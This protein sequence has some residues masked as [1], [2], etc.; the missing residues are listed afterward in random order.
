MKNF[1]WEMVR[2]IYE[3]KCASK[4]IPFIAIGKYNLKYLIYPN[5]A[6]DI[7]ICKNGI[8]GDFL[9]NCLNQF[10]DKDGVV[11]DI[12]ANVGL[13][14]LPFS[15]IHVPFGKVISF[16]PDEENFIQLKTNIN[17]NKIE[18]VIALP[19]ALQGDQAVGKINFNIRRAVDGDG[20]VNRGLSSLVDIDLH[21]VE[22]KEVVASTIDKEIL[23]LKLERLDFIKIDV[24]GMECDVLKGGKKSIGKYHPIIQYEYSLVID[25]L[26]NRKNSEQTFLFLQNMGYIQYMIRDEEKLIQLETPIQDGPDV[27]VIGFYKTDIPNNLL[28]N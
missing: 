19:V 13:L 16:E 23:R 28:K 17:I 6:L 3:K 25:K 1:F 27:N 8:L 4:N 21:T 22:R 12:G 24:E 5:S 26:A 20:N 10:V 7:H 2:Q 9:A 14:T 18:N 15:K 11:L